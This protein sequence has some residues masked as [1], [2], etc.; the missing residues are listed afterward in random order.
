MF[1]HFSPAFQRFVAPAQERPE[2]WR[3]TLGIILVFAIF[4]LTTLILGLGTAFWANILSPDL[5]RA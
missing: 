3:T 4:L 1:P 2:I 5:V